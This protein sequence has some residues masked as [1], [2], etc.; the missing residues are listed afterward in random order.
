MTKTHYKFIDLCSGIGG[1]HLGLHKLGMKC[2]FASEIDKTAREI[3]QQNF[4]NIEPSIF[5]NDRFNEDIFNVD[6]DK[7]PDFDICCAGFPCQPF[8][9]IG[10]KKGFGEN[11]E[12]RGT[13]FFKILEI[14]DNKRP[15]A[16]LLE[17]VQHIINHDGGNTFKTIENELRNIGYSFYY[18]VIRATD[19]GLPQHRPRTFMVG[20]NNED[21]ADEF[22]QFPCKIPLKMT[23]SDVFGGKCSR[24]IGFTLRLGG[25]ESPI[26]DRRN[27]DSYIVNGKI[28]KIEPEHGK[29]MQGFPKKFILPSSRTKAMKLL[30]NSVAVNVIYHLGKQI[31]DYL[32]DKNQFQK[33]QNLKLF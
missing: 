32:E 19:F 22:F 5:D 18:K 9:Q 21:L 25:A 13:L 1:F 27:W 28:K 23:M 3:Y 31:I 16:F 17:N 10:K 6:T 7:I 15:R 11:L 30:G 24:D 29:K 2:V 20:F 8:S 4:Y 26:D 33:N 12:N 14:I